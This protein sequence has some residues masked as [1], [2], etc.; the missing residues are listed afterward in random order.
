MAPC[1]AQECHASCTA[2]SPKCPT[3]LAQEHP[4][5]SGASQRLPFLMQSAISSS[6]AFLY[7]RHLQE[8]SP[9][10]QLLTCSARV[11]TACPRTRPPPLTASLLGHH[12]EQPLLTQE[13]LPDEAE[14]AVDD[15]G[16][17][18]HTKE[19]WCHTPD[20]LQERL[21]RPAH[22]GLGELGEV[23][24]GVPADRD[25]DE[26]E[27]REER[28]ED[29]QGGARGL[30]P[31]WRGSED[32]GGGEHPGSKDKRGGPRQPRWQAGRL[33]PRPPLLRPELHGRDPSLQGPARR[34]THRPPGARAR[35]E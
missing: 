18:V 15:N 14:D 32:G 28:K 27:G 21:R 13:D 22:N 23:H 1:E 5:S 7:T 6:A 10:P 16:A 20:H 24:L 29:V 26:E 17:N 19:R 33:A 3:R 34:G 9:G 30:Q 35:E 31:L 11:P 8:G 4:D 2:S 12:D 25:A